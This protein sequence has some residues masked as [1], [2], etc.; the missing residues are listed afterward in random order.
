MLFK[1]TSKT[2]QR[3]KNTLNI[4]IVKKN[5]KINAF[6]RLNV[7]LT[8]KKIISLIVQIVKKVYAQQ[9]MSSIK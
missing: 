1:K 3:K 4:I 7:F 9:K 8:S 5:Q 6:I 2:R